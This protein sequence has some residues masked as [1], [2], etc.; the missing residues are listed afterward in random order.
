MNRSI[1]PPNV[2]DKLYD[3]DQLAGDFPNYMYAQ[4]RLLSALNISFISRS[5]KPEMCALALVENQQ[6]PTDPEQAIERAQRATGGW[7]AG[8]SGLPAGGGAQ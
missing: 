8:D 3:L 5:R 4:Q 2:H 6:R 1:V 7:D